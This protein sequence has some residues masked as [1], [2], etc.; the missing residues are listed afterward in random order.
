[1]ATTTA[2]LLKVGIMLPNLEGMMAGATPRWSD[3]LAIASTAEAVGL[4]SVWVIDHLAFP[5]VYSLH[6]DGDRSRLNSELLMPRNERRHLR[7][8]NDVLGG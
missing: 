6:V 3:I 7:G 5:R 1:M 4:D 2:R 8:M